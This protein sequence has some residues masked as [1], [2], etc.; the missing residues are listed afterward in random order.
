MK[1]SGKLDQ[2]CHI[3]SHTNKHISILFAA[4]YFGTSSS[5]SEMVTLPSSGYFGYHTSG[6]LVT[7]TGNWAL[8][9]SFISR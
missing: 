5:S 6:H 9:Q 7:E 1:P 4:S 2:M 8:I 3:Y